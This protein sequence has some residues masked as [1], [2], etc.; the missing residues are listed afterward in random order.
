MRRVFPRRLLIVGR[1]FSLACALGLAVFPAHAGVFDDDEA[2]TRITK[3]RTEFDDQVKRI[4]LAAKNQLDFANQVETIQADAAKLRG[5][6]EVLANELESAQ[7]R[8]KDFYIDLDA[9]LRKIE[10]AAAESKAEAKS[11]APKTD[12]AAETRD[13]EAALTVLKG[14]QY[15]EALVAFLAFVKTYPSSG[16]LPSAHYWIASSYYQLKDFGR[17]AESFGYLA[18]TWPNDAKAPDALLAEA[19]AE[20]AG[21][22]IKAGRKTLEALI[23]KYPASSAAPAAKTRLKGLPSPKK[24]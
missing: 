5:Q 24:K 18:N 21:G 23:D 14:A 15:K 1:S 9:R 20:I 22:D 4:D 13:Y 7:K 8:Q 6:I 10:A 19:N 17:A 2:R 11:E 12:P 3:L 16:L